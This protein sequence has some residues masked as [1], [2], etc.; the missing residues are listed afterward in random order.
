MSDLE[1]I[2]KVLDE[3]GL[4]STTASIA[5]ECM[6]ELCQQCGVKKKL[7]KLGSLFE[8]LTD[9]V[10][11]FDLNSNIIDANR[12]GES[13]N[14]T[15][16][17]YYY[18]GKNY[19]ISNLPVIEE[20]L[21]SKTSSD[22]VV[23]VVG[24]DQNGNKH[25]FN[26]GCSPV[27]SETNILVGV[28]LIIADITQAQKQARQLEDIVSALTHDLKTP[29]VAA[30][31][32]VKHLLDGYFGNLTNDQRQILTLLNQ[33]NSDALK[34][35]KNLL[36]VFKY[37]TK[38]YK[39]LLEAVEIST[40]IEKAINVVKSLLEEKK[41]SL[42]V[43][44]VNFQFVCD[45]FEIERVIINLLT[46]A[47][48]FTPVSGHIELKA[49]KDEDGFVKIFIEDNGSG[50]PQDELPNLFERFWQSR[51]SNSG[52]NS[53]GLGLYLSRQIVEA[54]GGLIWADSESGKGTTVTFEIPNIP[55]EKTS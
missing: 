43:S 3:K 11:A 15:F 8:N 45:P 34:L 26:I 51:K 5:M 1:A 49:I 14:R 2:S 33:S 37:E 18:D 55:F 30:E 54:H 31:T 19:K 12:F 53:T 32:S 9:G 4:D 25:L 48:K 46:N 21:K 17:T 35:V 10:I 22:G 6:V 42:K 29:L 38:S 24:F 40:V 28:C 13:I 50:I 44:Q 41:I 39:L 7:A 36:T 52:S 47:I 16:K 23:E 27:F 20:V